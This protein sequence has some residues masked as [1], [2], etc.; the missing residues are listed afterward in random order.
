[1]NGISNMKALARFTN[2]SRLWVS[3]PDGLSWHTCN[4]VSF[5]RDGANVVAMLYDLHA[6]SSSTELDP[7]MVG[8]F[9]IPGPGALQVDDQ[10]PHLQVAVNGWT[11]DLRPAEDQFIRPDPYFS[12]EEIPADIKELVRLL[13]YGQV[14]L[15]Q[16]E[17]QRL[18]LGN[19]PEFGPLFDRIVEQAARR[20][21]KMEQEIARRVPR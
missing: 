20:V 19:D 12:M 16:S 17:A 3:Q 4:V 10:P 14:I 9:R 11:F 15:S 6:D 13:R 5:F 7:V 18:A 8:I 1:M 21:T 2:V